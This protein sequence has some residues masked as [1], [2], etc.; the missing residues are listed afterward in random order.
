MFFATDDVTPV[1]NSR[2]ADIR[3]KELRANQ[4]SLHYGGAC[5]LAGSARSDGTI[6]KAGVLA[7]EACSVIMKVFYGA[8]VVRVDLVRAITSLAQTMT[9]MVH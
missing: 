5:T 4:A 7:A 2:E 1:A 6:A 8:R 3:C 9:N